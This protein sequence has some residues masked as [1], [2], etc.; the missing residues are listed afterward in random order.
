MTS[1]PGPEMAAVG[2]DAGRKKYNSGGPRASPRGRRG[3]QPLA[4]GHRPLPREYWQL[5]MLTSPSPPMTSSAASTKRPPSPA[6][7]EIDPD[8]QDAGGK[9]Y[10]RRSQGASAGPGLAGSASKTSSRCL[11]PEL[12]R[13]RSWRESTRCH[14]RPVAH[15]HI[16]GVGMPRR[17]PGCRR[18]NYRCLP[19]AP[20]STCLPQ[21]HL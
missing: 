20:I 19:I 9:K 8:D 21:R 1:Q 15:R 2:R 12:S 4:F 18:H 17:C 14:R 6:R 3:P 5:S 13:E 16:A 10:Y 7:A 11:W